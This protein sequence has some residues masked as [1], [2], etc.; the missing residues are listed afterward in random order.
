MKR[1]YVVLAALCLLCVSVANVQANDIKSK[2]KGKWDITVPDAPGGYDRYEAEFK[3][4]DGDIV[5]DFKG[6]DLSIKEQKF[7]VRDGRLVAN[8]YVGEYVQL[9]IFEEKGV[10][11]GTADTSMGK[12]PF[13]LK[14]KTN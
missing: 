1:M 14:K 9:V 13:N 12:L 3:E 5:M 10:L 7:T 2:I 8:L 11:K 4:K 6:G